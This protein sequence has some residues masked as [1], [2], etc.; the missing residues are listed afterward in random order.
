LAKDD[1]VGLVDGTTTPECAAVVT[2]EKVGLADG[3]AVT[4]APEGGVVGVAVKDEVGLV[5][6]TFVWLHT[7]HDS[8]QTPYMSPSQKPSRELV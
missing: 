1:A 8:L 5:E 3:T 4:A 2:M 6:G 7:P